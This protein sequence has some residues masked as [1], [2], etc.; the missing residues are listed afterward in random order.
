MKF[1]SGKLYSLLDI[2]GGCV[3]CDDC[4]KESDSH[5][6]PEMALSK[7]KSEGWLLDAEKHF[8]PDCAKKK[9]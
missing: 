5:L 7:A 1:E 4:G 9:S 8:C 2:L 3:V 6:T